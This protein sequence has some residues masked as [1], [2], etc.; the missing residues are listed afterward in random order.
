MVSVLIFACR[1]RHGASWAWMWLLEAEW[2]RLA[3]MDQQPQQGS[4]LYRPSLAL[5]AIRSGRLTF[6]SRPTQAAMR[7]ITYL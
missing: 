3:T 6:L 1:K 5:G 2:A 4:S 7:E